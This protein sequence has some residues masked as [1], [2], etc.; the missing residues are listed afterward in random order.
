MPVSDIAATAADMPAVEG[1]RH[2]FVDLPGLR[3]HAAHAG[4]G[5]PVIMLHGLPQ[6]WWQWRAVATGLS[7]RYHLIC[8]DGRGFGW[9]QAESARID[10]YAMRD[11]VMALLDALELDRVRI[12][13]HDMGA[14][15]AAQLAY[16]HP[17]RVRAMVVLSVP[18]PFMRLG[19]GMLP[20]MRHVPKLRFRRPGSALDWVFRPP[21]VATAMSDE[22][23]AAYFAPLRDPAKDGAIREVYRGLLVGGEMPALVTGAYRRQRLRVPALYA[24]GAR[25]APLTESFVRSHVGDVERFADQVEFATVPDAAHFVTDDNPGAVQELIQE[26]FA[27]A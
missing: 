6:H 1:V 8:P 10:R 2:R 26:F 11:D 27:R 21:Y 23:M 19:P 9:S 24:F 12:V 18:P 20:A 22:T 4:I 7:G 3:V 16:T 17:E 14:L 13:A 5:D 25:D 15:V